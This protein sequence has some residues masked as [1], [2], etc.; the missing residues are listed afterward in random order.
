MDNSG[1][2]F[3][4]QACPRWTSLV[5]TAGSALQNR[6]STSGGQPEGGAK[7][8]GHRA[9][10]AGS[11]QR[12]WPLHPPPA[13]LHPPGSR[14]C[15]PCPGLDLPTAPACLATP[16]L[17]TSSQE[18]G[19]PP[20]L[21]RMPLGPPSVAPGP[22]SLGAPRLPPALLCGWPETALSEALCCFLSSKEPHFSSL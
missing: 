7:T 21:E 12:G 14:V 20:V 4:P 16:A 8:S 13:P 2:V 17:H 15:P 9:Q 6:L 3:Q 19:S 1:S 18:H 22:H 10:P 5:P 11:L